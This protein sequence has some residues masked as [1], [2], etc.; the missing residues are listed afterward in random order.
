MHRIL[1]RFPRIHA[2]DRFHQLTAIGP[3]FRVRPVV[4]GRFGK[5]KNATVYRCD[6]GNLTVQVRS[7]VRPR[8]WV[9]S[10]GCHRV[11]VGI[12]NGRA[13]RTHGGNGT[14]LYDLWH[15][16]KL[17]CYDAGQ[18]NYESYGGRGI[19]M[20]DEWRHD[21]AVFREWAISHGYRP[22][23]QI[24]RFPN[25]NG[26]Y[27]PENCRFTT[28]KENNNNRR[29]SVFVDWRGERKTLKQWSEDNRCA[30]AYHV[31]WRRW[32]NGWDFDHAM[33]VPPLPRG[34]ARR[35]RILPKVLIET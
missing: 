33:L 22:G 2:G 16:I 11:A 26:H 15:L 17:R 30:V 10:C 21:F 7:D 25:N 19:G 1:C 5:V 32:K 31:L 12:K 13:R 14:K 20:C 24:D 35:Y 3:E 28:C 9:M 18:E 6:C 27:E 4:N 29:S 23:L 34:L 8:N